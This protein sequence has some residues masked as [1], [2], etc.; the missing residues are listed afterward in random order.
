MNLGC[1]LDLKRIALHARNAEY[2]PKVCSITSLFT[3]DVCVH[4]CVLV[5]V[6]ICVCEYVKGCICMREFVCII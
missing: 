6:C 1:K 5:C 2:N 4:C 3:G